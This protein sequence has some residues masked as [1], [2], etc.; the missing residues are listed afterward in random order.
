MTIAQQKAR[1]F[2]REAIVSTPMSLP[3]SVQ[4]F[5]VHK[6]P[7]LP[8]RHPTSGHQVQRRDY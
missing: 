8:D 1:G 4:L 5:C 3:L 7:A 6:L 2:A